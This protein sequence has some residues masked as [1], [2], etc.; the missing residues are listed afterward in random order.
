MAHCYKTGG[1]V[2]S[3]ELL[4]S[5][6]GNKTW[7]EPIT[8]AWGSRKPDINCICKQT[9]LGFQGIQ[10]KKRIPFTEGIL[11]ALGFRK[12]PAPANEHLGVSEREGGMA[13]SSWQQRSVSR[14]HSAGPTLRISTTKGNYILSNEGI[15]TTEATLLKHF[16]CLPD[17]I[18]AS[19]AFAPSLGY[20][21]AKGCLPWYEER[22]NKVRLTAPWLLSISQRRD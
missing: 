16:P 7:W 4:C 19:F 15:E 3:W 13:A 12:A 5:S 2:N 21:Q 14:S 17:S 9:I 6:P 20:I 10:W 1:K 8:R 22:Q 11:S 18:S